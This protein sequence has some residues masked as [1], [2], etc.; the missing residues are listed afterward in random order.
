MEEKIVS[1]RLVIPWGLKVRIGV[2]DVFVK[3]TE[4]ALENHDIT[5]IFLN[6]TNSHSQQYGKITTDTM[7]LIMQSRCLLNSS[8]HTS[9][10]KHVVLDSVILFEKHS[11]DT[12]KVLKGKTVTI[13]HPWANPTKV[14][15]H[16]CMPNLIEVHSSKE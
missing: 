16:K 15:S 1:T 5:S 3:P 2:E 4:D 8:Y 13:E 10:D 9:V 6:S 11:V 14:G 7:S 12:R